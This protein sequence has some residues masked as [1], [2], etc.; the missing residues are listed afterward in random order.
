MGTICGG[1]QIREVITMIELRRVNG[2][3]IGTGESLIDVAQANKHRLYGAN[4]T[5]ARLDG[6]DLT[7]ADLSGA[8]LAGAQ[9]DGAN[10]TRAR[11]DGANLTRARLDGA[12]L[13]R[14][15]LTRARLDGANL[16]MARLDGA[17]LTRANFTDTCYHGVAPLQIFGS[18]HPITQTWDGEIAVGCEVHSVKQWLD[19]YE[20]IG[21]RNS[22]TPQQIEEYGRLLRFMADE[23]GRR[24]Q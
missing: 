24:G 16:A 8:R 22:Y 18:R 14:A 17:N 7:R 1:A 10:L 21:K 12:D 11:L 4:L 9:L 23:L 6:A 5:R 13:T 15:N 20:E 19:H 3:L 2:S